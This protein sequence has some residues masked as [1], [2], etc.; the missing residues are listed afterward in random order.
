MV[1]QSWAW[2]S[3]SSGHELRRVLVSEITVD[4][5]SNLKTKCGM[6]CISAVTLREIDVPKTCAKR[7][8]SHRVER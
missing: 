8:Q 5:N 6:L 7:M 4:Q 3:E 1:C 2:G